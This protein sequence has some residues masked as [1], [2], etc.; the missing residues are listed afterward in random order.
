MLNVHHIKHR[1]K[2]AIFS[3]IA[4]ILTNTFYFSTLELMRRVNRKQASR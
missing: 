1:N 3:Q 4:V 2:C